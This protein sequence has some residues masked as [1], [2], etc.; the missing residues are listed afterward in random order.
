V[1]CRPTRHDREKADIFQLCWSSAARTSPFVEREW[2]HALSKGRPGFIRPTYWEEPMPPP[3]PEL[4]YIHFAHLEIGWRRLRRRWK[5]FWGSHSA[6]L[7]G[8]V[9]LNKDP[10][11]SEFPELL[12]KTWNLLNSKRYFCIL[13][14]PT[15]L[16]FLYV[17]HR[18]LAE[19]LG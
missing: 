15:G 4:A 1:G 19:T 3:P 8:C 11:V 9:H 5:A 2:R 10:K 6:C 14:S 13:N 12:L 17:I 7:R 18:K 16:D